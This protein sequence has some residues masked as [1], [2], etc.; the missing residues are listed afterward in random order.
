MIPVRIV[1]IKYHIFERPPN[2]DVHFLLWTSIKF[3]PKRISTRILFHEYNS[4]YMHSLLTS[5]SKKV[6]LQLPGKQFW[7]T[8]YIL[9]AW[10]RHTTTPGPLSWR[11]GFK[12]KFVLS[13]C[14]VSSRCWIINKNLMWL[15][16]W[17][18]GNMKQGWQS[19]STLGQICNKPDTFWTYKDTDPN[20]TDNHWY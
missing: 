17:K 3:I 13:R 9:E 8:R 7:N 14:T 10:W 2:R 11:H 1:Y 15:S 19:G 18:Y 16:F 20:C 5:L 4:T 12:R 6:Y